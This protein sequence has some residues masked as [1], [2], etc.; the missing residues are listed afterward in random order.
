MDLYDY[1]Q[2]YYKITKKQNENIKNN[3]IDKL[4]ELTEKK[5][6]IIKQVEENTNLEDYLRNQDNPKKAFEELQNL[7]NKINVLEEENT[8]QIEDKRDELLEKMTDLN[9]KAKSRKGYL[10]QSNYEAKFI[11]EKS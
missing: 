7:M 6:E 5:N 9:Q 10:T 2:N 3:E 1:Y 4:S 11:D 8:E